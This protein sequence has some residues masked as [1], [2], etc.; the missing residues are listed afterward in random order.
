MTRSILPPAPDVPESAINELHALFH[1]G[2]D[3]EPD[4]KLDQRILAAARA[5]LATVRRTQSRRSVPWWKGWLAPASAIAVAA[6]GLSL[7]WH[8]MD[9]QERDLRRE[10]NAAVS[11]GKTADGGEDSAAPEV[12]TTEARPSINLR[13]PA[14]PP[15]ESKAVQN[16]SS[17]QQEHAADRVARTQVSPAVTVPAAPAAVPPV[18]ETEQLN[19]SGRAAADDL[20]EK[21]ESGDAGNAASGLASRQF[22][23]DAK[24]HDASTSAVTAADLSPSSAASP[25][26][27]AATPEAWLKRIRELRA[28]GRNAEAAQSLVRLRLRYPDLVLP[29]DLINL[30]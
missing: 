25:A 24:R 26:D 7:G 18:P 14:K 6:L 17:A 12:V 16:F 27:E 10:M 11:A 4:R 28:E 15:A 3:A 2:S 9:E 8:V 23:I 29:D 19:K 5:D 1:E 20:R 22:K 13:S 30:K 21:R